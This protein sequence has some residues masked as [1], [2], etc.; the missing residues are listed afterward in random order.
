MVRCTSEVT[1]LGEM[2]LRMQRLREW[3]WELETNESAGTQG[4]K[5]VR[6]RDGEM[7]ARQLSL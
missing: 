4:R 5:D 6:W 1:R 7:L 3:E 2:E